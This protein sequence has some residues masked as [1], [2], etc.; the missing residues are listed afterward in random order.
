MKERGYTLIEILIVLS[1]IGI[2]TAVGFAGYRDF[3]RRQSLAGIVK[4]VQGDL[5][6]AQQLSLSGVKPDGCST[7]PLDGIR[8]GI[9]TTTPSVYTIKAVCGS[10]PNKYPIVKQYTLP[11]DISINS[12]SPNPI[13]FKVLG[14]GTNIPSGSVTITFTQAVTANKA[15]ITVESGGVIK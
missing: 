2:L 13:I 6:L 1:V 5:R 3:S 12:F 9:T 11:S 4:Q 8:F 15:T 10:D 14:Q 7:N